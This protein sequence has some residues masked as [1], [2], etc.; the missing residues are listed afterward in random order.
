MDSSCGFWN[1]RIHEIVSDRELE[2]AEGGYSLPDNNALDAPVRPAISQSDVHGV[3]ARF[4]WACG[5]IV[6]LV[7]NREAELHK[8]EPN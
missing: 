5:G 8:P 2:T 7:R 3:F 4:P 6:D 1:I